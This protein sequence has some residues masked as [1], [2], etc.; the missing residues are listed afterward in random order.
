VIY[1]FGKDLLLNGH[2]HGIDGLVRI[3]ALLLRSRVEALVSSVS[4]Y[5]W[6]DVMLEYDLIGLRILIAILQKIE[7][8]FLPWG[9]IRPEL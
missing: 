6:L 7:V 1:L 8:Y 2:S 5:C 4:E 3:A 9:G